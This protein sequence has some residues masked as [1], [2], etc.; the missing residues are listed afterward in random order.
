MMSAGEKQ[1]VLD[2]YEAMPIKPEVKPWQILVSEAF[3]DGRAEDAIELLAE[4]DRFVLGR[5][6]EATLDELVNDWER[7][8]L[9]NPERVATVIARTHD[10]VQV[11]SHLMRERVLAR[12]WRGRTSGWWCGRAAPGLK[13]VRRISRS[14]GAISCGSGRWCGRSVSSTERWSR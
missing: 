11:L 5:G 2:D 1:R 7:W 8:R 9:E 6:L 4:R 13:T 3:R 10:E 14:R 12:G